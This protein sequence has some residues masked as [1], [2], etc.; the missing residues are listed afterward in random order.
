[1][2]MERGLTFDLAFTSLLSRAIKTLFYIQDMMP[3][4]LVPVVRDWRLNERHYGILQGQSKS[5]ILPN[6]AN[7]KSRSLT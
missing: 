6:T 5:E 7:N 2:L 3:L 1:M 4:H